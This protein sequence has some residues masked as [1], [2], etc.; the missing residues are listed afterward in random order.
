MD[1]WRQTTPRAASPHDTPT[2]APVD[3]LPAVKVSQVP[4]PVTALDVPLP[5][6]GA[7]KVPA[8]IRTILDPS[9][10][11]ADAIPPGSAVKSA[12]GLRLMMSQRTWAAWPNAA[13][14]HDSDSQQPSDHGGDAGRVPSLAPNPHATSMTHGAS[15]P[16]SGL[17]DVLATGRLAVRYAPS[18]TSV[19]GPRFGMPRGPTIS[20]TNSNGDHSTNWRG[21][22]LVS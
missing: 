3:T 8:P 18:W 12:G 1:Y 10:V 6:D 17:Q 20:R 4:P 14:T 21:G 5:P 7:T 19:T 16:S 22:F 15:H 13:E 11:R 2:V 9:L